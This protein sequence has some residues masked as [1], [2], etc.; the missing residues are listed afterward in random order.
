MSGELDENLIENV[1]ETHFIV[2]MDNGRTL[3]FKGDT[4]VK[5]ADV[6]SG[7]EGM[8]MIIRISGGIS[9]RIEA[10]MVIFKNKDRKYPIQGVPDN[11]AGVSYRTGPKGWNDKK[12]FPTWFAE[13][14]AYLPDRYGRVKAL[15]LDNCGG[16]N[17]SPELDAQL[18]R[19]KTKLR[20]FPPCTTDKLQPAD[21]FVISKIK[22]A[23]MERWEEK[24][25]EMIQNEQWSNEARSNGG[26]SGKL[27]FLKLAAES[28]RKV[29]SQRDENG[30]TYARKAM[31][32]CGLALDVSGEWRIGQLKPELQNIIHKHREYFDG[33]PLPL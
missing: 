26:W 9:S 33:K 25:H 3:G 8:T 21:S 27:F 20:F 18:V 1:D 4:N 2:N 10:P 23:W 17:S 32:R 7:G 31:I 30:L 15:F 14:R 12:L 22:D 19:T 29:N 28:V 24:K 6:V 5:Y 16:H 11:I 13:P